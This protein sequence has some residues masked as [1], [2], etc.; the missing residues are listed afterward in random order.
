MSLITAVVHRLPLS[1]TLLLETL[2]EF[3]HSNDNDDFDYV[4][5]SL[6]TVFPFNSYLIK[7]LKLISST[8]FKIYCFITF[9]LHVS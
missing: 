5:E 3:D 9:N 4:I 7:S 2:A 6:C 8:I 1:V